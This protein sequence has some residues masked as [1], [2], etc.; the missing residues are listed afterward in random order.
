MGTAFSKTPIPV[1][2]TTTSTP[3]PSAVPRTWG[4]LRRKP[5]RSPEA[6]SIVL[7]GPGDTEPTNAKTTGPTSSFTTGPVRTRSA[8]RPSKTAT[9]EGVLYDPCV[10]G[11]PRE[12]VRAWKPAVPGIHEVFHARFVDH[13]YPPHTHDAWTV[14]VVDE[15]AIKYDLET[16][17]R[18]V[19]G[20]RVTILPPHVVHD[21]RA[22]GAMG[23]RKRVLYVGTDVLD[24]RLIGPAV[25]DPDIEDHAAVQELR[26]LHRALGDPGE[27]LEAETLFALV[28]TRLQEH[29]G[30]RIVEPIERPYDEVAGDLR[31]LLDQ[32]RFEAMTLAEAGRI[33]HVSPAH[34]VRCFTRSFGIPPHHY[35]VARRIE[36]ARRR[37][38]DGEPVA[39]VAAG[40][41]FHDQAHLTRHFRRHVGTTPARYASSKASRSS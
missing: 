32:R 10:L 6:Q 29:L 5:N 36:A 22:A 8:S 7:F 19:A 40:V 35:V 20:A 25:D 27:V 28:S 39:Q 4:M 9:T 21:G 18:G 3:I 23:Y 14:F 16:R 2:T 11:M 30:D 41:G 12:W 17:H 15:G 34:L 37:L 13:A 26:T 38:L 24:E 31:D 33:I 1:A